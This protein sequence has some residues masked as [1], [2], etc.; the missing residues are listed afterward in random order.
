MHCLV[1]VDDFFR[2]DEEHSWA[3]GL[4]LLLAQ[5]QEESFMIEIAHD[6]SLVLDGHP[7]VE[8]PF[9]ERCEVV[10]CLLYTSDAADE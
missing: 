7:S 8:I 4:H 10:I 6:D 1:D 9:A 3:R 2:L 5:T